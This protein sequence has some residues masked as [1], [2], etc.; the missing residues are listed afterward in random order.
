MPEIRG[1]LSREGIVQGACVLCEQPSSSRM[2][3]PGLGGIE[4]PLHVLCAARIV[5]AYGL[6]RSGLPLPPGLHRMMSGY[7]ERV[8]R[9]GAGHASQD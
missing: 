2:V 5:R 1:Y 7:A 6:A 9:I 4:V 3:A 8:Q